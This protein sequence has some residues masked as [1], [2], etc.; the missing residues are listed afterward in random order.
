MNKHTKT[1]A[2]VRER[3][4][5]LHFR[6]HVGANASICSQK[7]NTK[8]FEKL[9][10]NVVVA[11][12]SVRLEKNQ[13]KKNIKIF[14][15]SKSNAVG[16]GVLDDPLVEQKHINK[17]TSNIP[18]SNIKNPTSNAAITLI[19]LIITIIVLLILAGVTLSMVMGESGIFS[20]ANS[21]K[22]QTQKST[23]E[24]AIKLAVLENS[25]KDAAGETA[26]NEPELKAEI[27]KKLKEL[28]Y[29]VAENNNTVTY[30]GDKT[31][32]I[33]DYFEKDTEKTTGI[34][35]K[36]VQK[37]PDWYYG[38]TVT[39]YTSSNGQNDW[40]IFYSDGNNIFLIT[41]DYTDLS[42][43]D[44]LNIE[45]GMTLVEGS[46]DR[47]CWKTEPD[48]QQIS[49]ETLKKFESKVYNINEHK[50]NTNVKCT[51]TLLNTDNW[52]N[53]LDKVNG[54]GS[55]EY[56]IGGPTL[57]MWIKSWNN[58]YSDIEG[59]IYYNKG[60][61]NEYYIELNSAVT[62]STLELKDKVGKD[63]I[64]FF[65]NGKEDTNRYWIASPYANSVTQMFNIDSNDKII[66]IRYYDYIWV[67]LRPVASLKSG[68]T[69]N[70][71]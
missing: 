58:L 52:K 46:K 16:V 17:I 50:D 39:N 43:M 4:R 27:S 7:S 10:L 24:E 49:E 36:D 14:E 6:E 32:N 37:H 26:L 23:A 2:T 15:K 53:Y 45:N 48:F 20:K 65:P 47:A 57:E 61:N 55:A 12:A 62:N 33:E 40:K 64:L 35:A 30:Y 44:K 18:T 22:E 67:S 42:Q 9:K 60:K 54:T 11:D 5:E 71:K 1:I 41:G 63:N 21:T 3:E 34:T 13:N 68:V 31:I 69:V 28:G 38:K 51:S 70:I 25:A 56:V 59:T 29:T 66:D 8:T 19:A